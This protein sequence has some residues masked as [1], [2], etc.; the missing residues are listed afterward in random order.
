MRIM[1]RLK[2]IAVMSLFIWI[3]AI[4]RE[5]CLILWEMQL[6]ITDQAAL[7]K[8]ISQWTA[9]QEENGARTTLGGTGLGLSIVKHVTEF[10]GGCVSVESQ[11]GVGSTFLVQLPAASLVQK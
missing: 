7:S 1:F 2:S 6:N 5:Y 9:Q 10:Y 11:S 4:F 8:P 3:A